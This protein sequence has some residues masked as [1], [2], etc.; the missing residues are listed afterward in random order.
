LCRTFEGEALDDDAL[1]AF[2]DT[3]ATGDAH[4]ACNYRYFMGVALD[5]QGRTDLA[6]RYWRLA[7]F[8]GPF[9]NYNATLAGAR[10]LV[11]RHGVGR[12]GIPE[13][14]ARQDE[15]AAAK[16]EADDDADRAEAEFGETDVGTA[17]I[18]DANGGAE[19]GDAGA[20]DRSI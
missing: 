6:E 9:E 2:D 10:L 16:A 12:G 4:F 13:E 1:K 3:I 5:R 15:E 20:V 8:G 7:A 18:D 19:A 11:E 17:D 14:L